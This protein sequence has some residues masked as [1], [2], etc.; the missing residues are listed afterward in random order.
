M[1]AR[2]AFPLLLLSTGLLPLHS[3]TPSLD[4]WL[5]EVSNANTLR[6]Q[7]R[8]VEAEQ[9]LRAAIDDARLL[10]PDL[11]PAATTYNNL[12]GTYQDL[13]RCEAAAHTY[14]RSLDLWEKVG[15]RGETYLLRT[16]NHLVG[17]L[18]E[19]AALQDAEHWQRTLVA[20]L[21]AAHP[22]RDRDPDVAQAIANRGS[23]QFVKHRYARARADYEEALA[24]RER[25]A[26]GPSRETAVVLSNLAFTLIR[27]GQRTHALE[28]SR[29]A[30]A[31]IESTG[32][33]SDPLTIATLVNGA[34]LFLLARQWD[35]AEP[36]IE[37][38]LAAARAV[39]G[40]E[41]PLTASAMSGYAAVLKE[42]HRKQE[43]AV[44]ETRAR[45]IRGRLLRSAMRQTVDVRELSLPK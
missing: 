44:L 30:V 10:E 42:R 26:S 40:E 2:T 32:A 28:T 36:L 24:I 25:A 8:L 6:T 9:L 22:G 23:I 5:S 45:E 16:A 18:L 29:R 38:A 37:R 17:L 13:G 12:A 19:C 31:M 11:A 7:G 33:P 35:E 41:H 21:I 3:Q 39:L 43:A 34:N 20:R 27:T 1:D 15:A 14:Q 4:R